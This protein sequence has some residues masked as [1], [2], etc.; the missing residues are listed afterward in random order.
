MAKY[1]ISNCLYLS[2]IWD[3]DAND[4]DANEEKVSSET[5]AEI[6]E[7]FEK[8]SAYAESIG[9]KASFEDDFWIRRAWEEEA[10][11]PETRLTIFEYSEDVEISYNGKKLPR[12]SGPRYLDCFP[13]KPGDIF[14]LKPT[15]RCERWLK[16]AGGWMTE[17]LSEKK[18][19]Q[20]V[21]PATA[22]GYAA[23]DCIYS[24]TVNG[25]NEGY[26]LKP[27]NSFIDF[28]GWIKDV[29]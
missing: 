26:L 14:T 21:V 7:L 24:Y 20:F 16:E 12:E 13:C 29:L 19:F 5:R 27:N 17:I 4:V 3:F 25:V 8:L 6:S 23:L 2:K 15:K 28:G 1:V 10:K 18:E 22:K 11:D 9:L